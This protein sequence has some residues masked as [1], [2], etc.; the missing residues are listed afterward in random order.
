MK[1]SSDNNHCKMYNKDILKNDSSTESYFESKIHWEYNVSGKCTYGDPVIV[2]T[3]LQY[4]SSEIVLSNYV[5]LEN[6]EKPY[7]GDKCAK[8]AEL[9]SDF[10]QSIMNSGDFSFGWTATVQDDI[11]HTFSTTSTADIVYDLKA[12]TLDNGLWF[13]NDADVTLPGSSYTLQILSPHT[14]TVNNNAGS[15]PFAFDPSTLKLTVSGTNDFQS[16]GTSYE[17]T[18]EFKLCVN[19]NDACD[20]FDL[21]YTN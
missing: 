9:K 5:V 15:D 19:T 16:S 8:L 3:A 17:G 2:V 10:C 1:T 21:A 12:H 20:R 11:S 6:I 18:I 4:D 7:T 14:E 13:C